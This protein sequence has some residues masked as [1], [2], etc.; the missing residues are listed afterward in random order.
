MILCVKRIIFFN[1]IVFL[2]MHTCVSLELMLLTFSFH[3]I[4]LENVLHITLFEKCVSIGENMY[5]NMHSLDL[6]LH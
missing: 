3:L 4:T 6:L 2:S 5:C 1:Q